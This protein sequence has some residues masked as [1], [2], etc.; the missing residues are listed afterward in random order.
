MFKNKMMSIVKLLNRSDTKTEEPRCVF[1]VV[2]YQRIA[3]YRY[4]FT[5]LHEGLLLVC[6]GQTVTTKV[7]N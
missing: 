7:T 1:N 4:D 5:K 6:Y 2:M 3:P